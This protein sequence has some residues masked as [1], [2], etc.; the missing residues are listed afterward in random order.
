[1][2]LF[3]HGPSL[4]INHGNF[5]LSERKQGMVRK[6]KLQSKILVQLRNVVLDILHQP[7]FTSPL[8]PAMNLRELQWGSFASWLLFGQDQQE[9]LVE[10]GRVGE[11]Q[12]LFYFFFFPQFLPDRDT[13]YYRLFSFPSP[14]FLQALYLDAILPS[15]YSFKIYT[16]RRQSPPLRPDLGGLISCNDFSLA[17]PSCL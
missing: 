13:V 12:G 7:L 10:G 17:S 14:Q 3:L 6:T 5:C 16:G 11:K 2:I 1:M 15:P 4:F 9:A 8:C